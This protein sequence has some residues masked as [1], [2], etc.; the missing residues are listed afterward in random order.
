MNLCRFFFIETYHFIEIKF[1]Q[2]I[3]NHFLGNIIILFTTS[4]YFIYK[5]LKQWN[6]NITCF[7]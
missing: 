4:F 2:Q 3:F 1:S 7:V 5:R 6:I